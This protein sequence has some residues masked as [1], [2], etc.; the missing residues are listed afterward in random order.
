MLI[1]QTQ[2]FTQWTLALGASERARYN[3]HWATQH[4]TQEQAADAGEAYG[5]A[6]ATLEAKRLIL[7]R[8][9]DMTAHQRIDALEIEALKWLTKTTNEGNK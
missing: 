6:S 4:L 3:A 9:M 2:E 7:A 1:E 5:L 8:T